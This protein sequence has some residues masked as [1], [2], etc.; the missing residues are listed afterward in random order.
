MLLIL[1]NTY[2]LPPFFCIY[3]YFFCFPSI[4]LTPS[5]WS[6]SAFQCMGLLPNLFYLQLQIQQAHFIVLL[7]VHFVSKQH[8]HQPCLWV[9]WTPAESINF[10]HWSSSFARWQGIKIFL[11]NLNYK[12]RNQVKQSSKLRSS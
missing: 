5:W 2:S 10:S 12:K 9:Q 7:E 11:E 8:N 6:V 4:R 1:T 3:M